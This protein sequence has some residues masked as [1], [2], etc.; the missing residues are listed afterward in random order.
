[1]ILSISTSRVAGIRAVIHHTR[2]RIV[3]FKKQS[4]E[5]TQSHVHSES[6]VTYRP[7]RIIEYLKISNT[8]R[9]K[10]GGRKERKRERRK[11]GRKKERSIAEG[12][13]RD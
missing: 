5:H 6:I 4:F 10:E 1:V 13:D 8:E 12:S 7:Q 3:F 9:E 11:E 2:P